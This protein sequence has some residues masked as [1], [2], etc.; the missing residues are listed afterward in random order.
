LRLPREFFCKDPITLAIDLLGKLLVHESPEGRTSGIVV[1]TEAYLG[2][3]D[4]ASHGYGGRRTPRMEPLY[5]P[6]GHAYV[7][8]VHG[9]PLL[10]V[11]AGPPGEPTAVLIRALEPREG[12]E[13]M[14][15]RRGIVLN[16]P[17]DLK[18]LCSGPGKLTQAMGITVEHNGVDLV[19]GSLYFE[20]AGYEVKEV[21]RRPRIGVDYAGEDALKPLRFYIAGNRFVSK[22]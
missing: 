3:T 10:N 2:K 7:Y 5:G 21:V 6:C 11:V 15:K 18:K 13:L 8:V 20:D 19:E 17:P 12:I 14:A 16:R 1:E 4:R 9:K 22:R